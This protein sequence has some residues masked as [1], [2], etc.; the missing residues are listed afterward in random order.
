MTDL[1]TTDKCLLFDIVRECIRTEGECLEACRRK[2]P[3]GNPL[4][5]RQSVFVTLSLGGKLRGCIGNLRSDWPLWEAAGRMGCQ[6]A[7]M[8][9][10]FD[11]VHVDEI[12][13]LEIEIS[14]LTSPQPVESLDEIETG[15]D[16]LIVEGNR[17]R[18]LLLPQVAIHRG[19]DKITFIEQTCQK[20]GLPPDAWKSDSVQ[21]S[22]FQA[23][24]LSE[25]EL[26]EH[27]EVPPAVGT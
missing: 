17:R 26:I 21:I 4:M 22:R 13:N 27:R 7:Y 6:A 15:R 8:D 18:G 19:W 2:V 11:P 10:R 3:P 25:R 16:G 23:V 20:A 1:S 12:P 24:V 14:I 5:E 9:P